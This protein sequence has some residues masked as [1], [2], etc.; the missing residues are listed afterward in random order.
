MI[1]DHYLEMLA[2]SGITREHAEARPYETVTDP[3]RLQELGFARDACKCVPGLLIPL[4]DARGSTWGYQ[5]RPDYPRFDRKGKPIKYETPVGQC[6]GIDIPPGV[7]DLLGDPTVSLFVTEGSK[8]ADCA[9]LYGLC[10][11]ALI[12]VWGFRGT[13]TKGGVTALADWNDITLE[14]RDVIPAYDGDVARNPKVAKAICALADY[15]R[16]RKAKVRYLHLP[17]ED[18]KVGLDDWLTTDGHTVEDLWKLAKT[19]QPPIRNRPEEAVAGEQPTN[20][21]DGSQFF[22][23]SGLLAR[24]LADAV[25][26]SVTCGFGHPDQRFYTYDSG[27]WLP[28]DGRIEA[29]I[30][31]LLGNR[32]R[33]AHTR[34]VLDLIRHSPCTARIADNPL[35]DYVNVPNGMIAWRT[36]RLLPHSPDYRSTVQLPVEYR[37]GA[38]C[39]LFEKFVAEV[40]P[41]DLYEPTGDSLG[42]IWELI[43]Y[44][45]YSGNPLHIAVLLY[46]KGRNGKGT[47]IRVLKQL[48]G[49]RN[50]STVGLHQL[51]ENRFRAAT[52]FGKLANLAGDLDSRWLDNT[53]MFKAIT[54]GDTIQ[55]EYKYGAR[56][57]LHAVGTAVLLDQQGVR[58]GRLLGGLGGAVGGGAVPD[59]LPMAAKTGRWM[60][61]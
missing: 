44:T 14:G 37:P 30:T 29:Q 46:G 45:L 26:A 50:C 60:P 32:Y 59:E 42:F 53:A 6:N 22:G 2:A 61:S 11:V 31:R 49:A 27:V 34:S 57:R 5:Y 15:L 21:G 20:T 51:V 40:L 36:R 54:G 35:A 24:D 52:L 8:K 7:G 3:R 41:K 10:C 47:L 39:P 1:A 16:F 28:D 23:R 56:V 13:N 9:A 48:L 19:D 55:A 43:G 12:G 38:E 33:S 17:D 18:E 4:L 25:M 58:L